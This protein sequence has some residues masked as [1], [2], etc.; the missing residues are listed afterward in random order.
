MARFL[1]HT[2]GQDQLPRH[3]AAALASSPYAARL[4]AA[5]EPGLGGLGRVLLQDVLSP[6]MCYV[7][8]CALMHQQLS[9]HLYV[10]SDMELEAWTAR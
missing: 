7:D 3:F 4:S 2:Q 5:K 9:I 8:P 6:G 1:L 10:T